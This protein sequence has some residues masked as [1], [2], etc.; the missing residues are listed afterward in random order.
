MNMPKRMS[1]TTYNNI[2]TNI[3]NSTKTVAEQMTD[4]ARETNNPGNVIYTGVS[5]IG[6]CQRRGY[7]TG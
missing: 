6:T 7:L 1:K 3:R 2:S 4:A 5:V